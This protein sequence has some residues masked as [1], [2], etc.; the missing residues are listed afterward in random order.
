MFLRAGQMADLDSMRQEKLN[1]AAR[2]IQRYLRAL[3]QRR[4]YARLKKATI[5][6]Q[7]RWRGEDSPHPPQPLSLLPP[8]SSLL[9][10]RIGF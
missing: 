2:V 1:N 6:A 7:A 9:R 5:M 4:A 10:F 8:P 3:L